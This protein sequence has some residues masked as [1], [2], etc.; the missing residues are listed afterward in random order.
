[1]DLKVVRFRFV[2]FSLG[3]LQLTVHKYKSYSISQL[4]STKEAALVGKNMAEKLQL[5]EPP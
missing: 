5:S 2:P 4:V 3:N 1:M